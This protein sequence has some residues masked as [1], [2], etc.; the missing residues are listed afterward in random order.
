MR[1]F[2][3]VCLGG[4][5]G[6]ALLYAIYLSLAIRALDSKTQKLLYRK[7]YESAHQ[8]DLRVELSQDLG[9]A[10]GKYIP[11]RRKIFLRTEFTGDPFLLAHEIGHH[12]ALR[13]YNDSTESKANLMARRLVESFLPWWRRCFGKWVLDIYFEH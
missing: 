10:A 2:L 11:H 13:E 9:N 3:F 8:M 7:L 4:M 1:I 12:I 5:F 6:L